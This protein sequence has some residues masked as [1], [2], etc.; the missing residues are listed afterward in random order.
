MQPWKK[1]RKRLN[2]CLPK[3]SHFVFSSNGLFCYDKWIQ[4][5]LCT[6]WSYCKN[7]CSL[8]R[9]LPN[10]TNYHQKTITRLVIFTVDW[11]YCHLSNAKR[12]FTKMYTCKT[13]EVVWL[14][15]LQNYQSQ[16]FCKAKKLACRGNFRVALAAIQMQNS[17]CFHGLIA[18][19]RFFGPNFN[20]IDPIWSC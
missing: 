11:F 17:M 10:Q 19:G 1:T 13:N 8:W 9:R 12:S 18:I 3:K 20:W 16:F 4:I 14:G 5:A 15:L 6:S 2:F 7:I